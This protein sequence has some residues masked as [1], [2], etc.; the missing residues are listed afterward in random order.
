MGWS[1]SA[2]CIGADDALAM[3]R[4]DGTLLRAKAIPNGMLGYLI[5]KLVLHRLGMVL[6]AC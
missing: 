5:G 1:P 4:E 3:E 6:A 2:A